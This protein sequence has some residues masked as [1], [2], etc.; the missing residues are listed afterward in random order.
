MGFANSDAFTAISAQLND[1]CAGPFNAGKVDLNVK[2]EGF[3]L[4]NCFKDD[5]IASKVELKADDAL[6]G[7]A[8]GFTLPV[9]KTFD[10]KDLNIS[11]AKEISNLKLQLDTT[12]TPSSGGVGNVVKAEFN[13]D[14][15]S[16]G[17]NVNAADVKAA[18]LH[19]AANYNG[20]T[21]G[22]KGP[23]SN[24]SALNYVFAPHKNLVIETDLAKFNLGYLL[25][26]PQHEVGLKYS[27]TKNEKEHDFVFA[28]KKKIGDADVH[29]KA[30]LSGQFNAA[31]VSHV[32]FGEF[33]NVKC[34]LGA[35]FNI[36]NWTTPKFG[37]GFDFSF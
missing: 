4:K 37:A 10:G 26:G 25:A 31:H 27:F 34:T 5:T 14:I 22:V 33:K 29:I 13:G 11:I 20:I 24:L 30:D 9:A 23:A 3:V 16:A 8:S 1:L 36:L 32:D 15:A 12:Y 19:A 21:V 2:S 28:A 7:L 17:L 6:L 35:Q 18:T